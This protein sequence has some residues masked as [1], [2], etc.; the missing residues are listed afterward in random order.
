M[1]GENL[2]ED[3]WNK[4]NSGLISISKQ[5]DIVNRYVYRVEKGQA[6][7][8]DELIIVD[9]LLVHIDELIDVLI[10]NV[11]ANKGALEQTG[12]YV[13]STTMLPLLKEELASSRI[14]L[15]LTPFWKDLPEEIT[16]TPATVLDGDTIEEY[17]GHKI[18]F[19][20]ID[21]HEI[22]SVAGQAEID[23]LKSLIEGK[24]V[25][26][27]IDEHNK[28]DVYG[29]ILGVPFLGTT[30]ISHAMLK[31]F[32]PS[33]L[34]E[35]KYQKRHKYVDWD[36]NKL[37]AEQ[38]EVPVPEPV[39]VPVA[40]NIGSLKVSSSPSNAKIFLD[41]HDTGL[42]TSETIDNLPARSYDIT[43]QLE[44]YETL[45]FSVDVERGKIYE[46]FKSLVKLPAPAKPAKP[47]RT[48]LESHFKAGII[49]EAGAIS[50]LTDL[51]YDVDA[52]NNYIE[53]WIGELK[54][55]QIANIYKTGVAGTA[56]TTL[57]L[58]MQGYTTADID[59]LLKLWDKE[60]EEE[61]IAATLGNIYVTSTPKYAN[62]Y[63]DGVYQNTVTPALLRGLTPGTYTVKVS[64]YAHQDS[65]QEVQVVAG[66]QADVDFVLV[67]A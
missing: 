2:I 48:T 39:A 42:R 35:T 38:K 17:D 7:S 60:I 31:Q 43:L 64:A 1:M 30:N 24:A 27:K 61:A 10:S 36:E 8:E 54:L 29:R 46:A 59:G 62:I 14:M 11:E 4:I 13:Y 40:E 49:S 56:R 16:V 23:Y 19:V 65:E 21:A 12:M 6:L 67:A 28:A 3:E 34:T 55:W 37:I 41:G 63:L 57:Y 26:V 20:G 52:I 66:T 47:T 15:G 9:G 44:G 51:G 53:E 45:P 33:I 5:F 25:T 50:G 22:G 58:E 32:G 18:R